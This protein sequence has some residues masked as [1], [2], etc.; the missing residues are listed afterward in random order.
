MGLEKSLPQLLVR[1][2]YADACRTPCA[3]PSKL[4]CLKGESDGNTNPLEV[5]VPPIFLLTLF[6]AA[7]GLFYRNVRRTLFLYQSSR[8]DSDAQWALDCISMTRSVSTAQMQGN[9]LITLVVGL[10]LLAVSAWMAFRAPCADV[11]SSLAR[12]D[13]SSIPTCHGN[14]DILQRAVSSCTSP[15][16]R[17]VCTPSSQHDVI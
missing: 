9:D 17:S 3:V 4:C 11:C 10:P 2:G 15:C 8:R 5:V 12:W 14:T 1:F 13:S 6:A 16:S 7:M